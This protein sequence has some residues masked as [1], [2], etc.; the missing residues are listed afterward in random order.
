MPRIAPELKTGVMRSS[1]HWKW[2]EC[3][4]GRSWG[5]QAWTTHLQTF[6][7]T[8]CLHDYVEGMQEE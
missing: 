3:L 2:A 1:W 8:L 7:L 5:T 4:R 6:L